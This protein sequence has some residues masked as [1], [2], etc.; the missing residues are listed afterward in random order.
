M[1]RER[2]NVFVCHLD[3]DLAHPRNVVVSNGLTV[4]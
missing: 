3:V 4:R 1:P 2:S